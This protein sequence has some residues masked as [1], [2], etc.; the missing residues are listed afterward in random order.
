M[1]SHTLPEVY[2]SGVYIAFRI[3]TFA[4]GTRIGVNSN[5]LVTFMAS[6]VDV[7]KEHNHWFSAVLLFDIK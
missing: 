5:V 4:F 1:K 6:V 7:V 2:F 3:Q